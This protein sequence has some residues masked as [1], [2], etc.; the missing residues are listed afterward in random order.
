MD[1]Q[2]H[3]S[4]DRH[5]TPPP[6]SSPARSSPARARS[7]RAARRRPRPVPYQ[8]T[9]RADFFEEEVGLE[10][11][12][13]RPIVNTRDEPHAD[14]E[15]PPAPRDRGRRQHERGRDPPQGRHHRD[16]VGHDRGRRLERGH[17]FASRSRRC[18][19]VPRPDADAA[20]RLADGVAP[21]PPS[22]SSGSCWPARAGPSAT[23]STP[24]ARTSARRSCE[25]WERRPRWSR[26]RP[27]ALADQLDWVAKQRLIDGYPDRHGLDWGDARLRALDA[28]VPR[29]APREVAG[30]PALGLQRWSTRPRPSW[31]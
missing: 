21:S 11:T 7:A 25:R 30:S 5:R 16:R 19:Q 29:P 13:K 12:L 26:A 27:R 10:T 18:D 24:S 8:L 9:Q 1:R 23:A 28:A 2:P 4:A 31:P 3:R 20:A 14:P 22:R 17:V 15:V 6:T